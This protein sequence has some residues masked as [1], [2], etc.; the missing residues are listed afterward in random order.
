MLDYIAYTIYYILMNLGYFSTTLF[1]W[2]YCSKYND[3]RVIV[4]YYS[5]ILIGSVKYLRGFKNI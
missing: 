5:N 3:V 2:K 4:I 1:Y